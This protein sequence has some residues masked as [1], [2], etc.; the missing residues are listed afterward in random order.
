VERLWAYLVDPEKRREWFGGGPLEP[1]EGGRVLFEFHF[2]ELTREPSPP[3][4]PESCVLPG[5]VLRCDPPRLLSFTWGDGPEASEATFELS[6]EGRDVRLVVTHRR[7]PG[8]P[9]MAG[10][11]SGWHAHLELL[12]DRLLGRPLRPFW[13]TKTALEA[14]YRKRLSRKAPR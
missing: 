7:L 11:G 2:G 6:P 3:G 12:E 14:A 13:A 10:V 9:E 8:L 5:R 4:G 1:R